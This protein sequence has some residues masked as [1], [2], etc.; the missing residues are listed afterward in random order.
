MS[1]LK[2]TEVQKK[3]ETEAEELLILRNINLVIEAGTTTVI[4]GESGCGKSTLLNI[5][6]GLDRADSG[7]IEVNDRNI[8]SLNEIQLSEYRKRQIGFIFQFH[9]LL[10][11]FTCIENVMMPYFM[12]GSSRK[13]SMQKA[14]E[15]LERV[16]LSERL[17]HYPSQMSGGERQRAALARALIN[18]PEIILADEPTGNLD[19][20]NSR[21]VENLLFDMVSD[22]GKTL[23][24]VTH[25][26]ELAGRGHDE[27]HLHKGELH[28]R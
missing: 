21:V 3:F 6:G 23:L 26:T 13:E 4:T 1:L 7:L 19:E 17:N 28:R 14:G 25:D 2:L 24:L 15:I 12:A 5:I 11:D 22:F 20:E 9:Y 10:K 18:N 16:K 27:Y 8:D